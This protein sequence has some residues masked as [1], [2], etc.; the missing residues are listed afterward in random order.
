MPETIPPTGTRWVRR[1]GHE[2]YDRPEP[3][4]AREPLPMPGR[5]KDHAPAP[6]SNPASRR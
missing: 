3:T 2:D 1:N 6:A 4:Q 5:D